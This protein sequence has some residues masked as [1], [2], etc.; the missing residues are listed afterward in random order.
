[1]KELMES[2]RYKDVI[3]VYQQQSPTN[4]GS[5]LAL[6]ACAKL[7]D[8]ENGVRIHQALPAELRQDH[9]IQ[10]SLIH[11]YSEKNR[12]KSFLIVRLVLL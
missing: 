8:Y 10:T 4:V 3:K 11:F 7:G 2:R 9:F 6:R 1:M 12:D 5:S